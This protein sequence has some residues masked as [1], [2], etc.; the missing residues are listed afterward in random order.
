MLKFTILITILIYVN[1]AATS[2]EEDLKDQLLLKILETKNR[3]FDQVQT[4]KV[5]ANGHLNKFNALVTEMVEKS[6]SDMDILKKE[7]GN[8][9]ESCY[10][11][12][13]DDID[14]N[15]LKTIAQFKSCIEKV[16]DAVD[17]DMESIAFEASLL[18]KEIQNTENINEELYRKVAEF[19]ESFQFAKYM[20]KLGKCKANSNLPRF[21]R[22][23][24]ETWIS[25]KQCLFRE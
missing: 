6:K 16:T 19:A 23:I 17:T 5:L 13:A 15:A 4:I 18:A 11:K 12:A 20:E 14:N 9:N 2:T 1:G 25:Y 3:A 22:Q 10:D 7:L 21:K 8:T 24:S